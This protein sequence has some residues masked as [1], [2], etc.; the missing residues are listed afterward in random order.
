MA[1]AAYKTEI[2]AAGETVT[3]EKTRPSRPRD[4]QQNDSN[5]ARLR[6]NNFERM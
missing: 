3:A 4:I 5:Q 1:W 2:T 6:K